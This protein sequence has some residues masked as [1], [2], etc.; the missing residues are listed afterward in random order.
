MSAKIRAKMT[1]QTVT[2]NPYSDVVEFT[3]VYG[4]STNAE[5]NTYAKATPSGSLKLQIDNP[6][7]RGLIKPGKTF[8]VDLTPID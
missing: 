7:V 8:Y 5:D 6:N 1:V 4:G 3:A 2:L